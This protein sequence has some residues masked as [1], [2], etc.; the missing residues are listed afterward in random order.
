MLKIFKTAGSKV[1]VTNKETINY[2]KK[3]KINFFAL[4]KKIEKRYYGVFV[5]K[6]HETNFNAFSLVV[7]S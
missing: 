6:F 1:K 3:Q 7:A 2:L 4:N 5:N